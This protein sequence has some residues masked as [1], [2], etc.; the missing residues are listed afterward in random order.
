MFF[1]D[2]AWLNQA[3]ERKFYSSEA[4]EHEKAAALASE[5]R[6]H[7]HDVSLRCD[8]LFADLAAAR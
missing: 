5:Y 3:G 2:V 1:V 6:A 8:E 7:G 4:L